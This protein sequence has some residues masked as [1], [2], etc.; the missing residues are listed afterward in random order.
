MSTMFSRLPPMYPMDAFLAVVRDAANELIRNVQA[1]DALV[2][3]SLIN[4]MSVACQGLIDVKLPTGQVRPVSQ[5]LLLVAASGERKSTVAKLVMSPFSEADSQAEAAHKQKV[6]QYQAEL[7]LWRA[8]AKGMRSAISRATSK[9]QSTEELDRQLIDHAL[10]KPSEPRLRRLLREDITVTAIREALQ[11]DGE[12]IAI[13]TDEGHMLFKGDAMR[14]VGLLN[15]LWDSPEMLPRDRPDDDHRLVMNPRVSVSI[16]T[17][18]GPLKE[19]LE[20][21]GAIA[22]ESGHWARYL[23]GSPPSRMGY[24]LVNADEPTWDCLPTF[25]A[26]VRELLAQH[27]TMIESG[28]IERKLVGFTVDAKT[29]WVDLASQTEGLLRQGEYLSDIND[30]ASKVMEILARLAATMHHFSGEV[31]DIT[32][33]TLERA[34]AIVRWHI[35]E[36]K[37]LF[38]PQFVV[39]QDLVDAQAVAAYLHSRVWQGPTSDTHI[40]KNHVLRNGPVRERNRLNAALG[41]LAARGAIWIWTGARDKRTYVRLHNTFFGQTPMAL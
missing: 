7:G 22:R 3:M 41:L 15:R 30:F 35:E 13:T 10:A 4:A 25:H 14:H 1:A 27:R 16:M 39:P 37:F 29:R 26:R 20:K 5:N 9:G 33:D 38:S 28:K 40:P 19:F 34:F 23:V 21:G 24:R 31:G 2:G 11:G 8:K 17:Q 36:Y 32:L 6:D 18:P 12:S